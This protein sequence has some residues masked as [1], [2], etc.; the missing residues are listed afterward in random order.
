MTKI[1]YLSK[2]PIRMYFTQLI[3]W[4]KIVLFCKV[5]S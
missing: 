4:Q 3:T 5:K 2:C 1:V